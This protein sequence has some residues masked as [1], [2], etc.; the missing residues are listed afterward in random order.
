MFDNE[1]EGKRTKTAQQKKKESKQHTRTGQK[2]H[3]RQ[4][5]I[6]FFKN[7]MKLKAL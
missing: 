7:C 5:E 3:V 2:N 6:A 1:T 4:K